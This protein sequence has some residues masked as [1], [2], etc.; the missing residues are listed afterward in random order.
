MVKQLTDEIIDAIGEKPFNIDLAE[1]SVRCRRFL[2]QEL[3]AVYRAIDSE[4]DEP[5]GF[6]ALCA[7]HALYAEGPSGSFRSSMSIRPIAQRE[8]AES[9]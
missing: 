9:W 7:S 8:S 2:E 4:S 1:T 3:Y 5:L 6:I